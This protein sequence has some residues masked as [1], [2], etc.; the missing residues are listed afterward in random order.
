L[1]TIVI[2]LWAESNTVPEEYDGYHVNPSYVYIK[3]ALVDAFVPATMK[4]DV[5][6]FWGRVVVIGSVRGLAWGYTILG[7]NP[8]LCVVIMLRDLISAGNQ[9][10]PL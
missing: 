6:A 4:V 9:L 8:K 7:A 5:C 3:R 1:Y 2:I 10:I